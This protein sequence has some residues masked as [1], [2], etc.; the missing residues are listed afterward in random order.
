[1][2]NDFQTYSFGRN[3]SITTVE[4][5]NRV[6]R[7][8][9]WLLALSMIP[10]VFGAWL[11]VSAGFSLFSAT[12]PG[13]GLMLFMAIA[14]GFMFAIQRFKNSGVGVAL[15][16]GFTFFMGLMLS[17]PIEF[18]AGFFKWRVVNHARV[19]RHGRHF[20]RDGIDRN[21]FKT[22]FFRS[23]QMAIHGRSCAAHRVSR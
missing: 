3:G 21:C 15:L 19:W 4:T 2:K 9:Y 16:L 1:M 20:Y 17:T 5:R 11:G 14:F 22:G 7:N 18:C 12:S 6:L 13:I 8:T 10:S 23:W